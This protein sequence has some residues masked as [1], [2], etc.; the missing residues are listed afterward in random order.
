M[1]YSVQ[2]GTVIICMMVFLH[3]VFITCGCSKIKP[4]KNKDGSY[5]HDC[6]VVIAQLRVAALLPFLLLCS[7]ALTV[8]LG[9]FLEFRSKPVLLQNQQVFKDIIKLED[10][11]DSVYVNSDIKYVKEQF[12]KSQTLNKIY[13]F[14]ENTQYVLGVIVAINLLLI[15]YS[16]C[17][18]QSFRILC[19]FRK[20]EQLVPSY[21]DQRKQ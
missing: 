5:I 3:Y 17:K 4:A 13:T 21:K 1:L 18:L 14:V 12:N 7:G 16:V 10:C 6:T 8:L 19:N 11:F 2:L 20:I 9:L 15:L